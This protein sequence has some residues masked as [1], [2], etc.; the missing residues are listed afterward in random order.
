MANLPD[1]PRGDPPPPEARRVSNEQFELVIRRAAELQAE[2]DEGVAEGLSEEEV[3]R[4][5]RELGLTG[6]NLQRALA[7]V[8]RKTTAPTGALDRYM[9]AAEA[10]A[11][12]TIPMEP[13]RAR[14]LLEGHLVQREFYEVQRRF[15][16][17]L[18]LVE[19]SGVGAAIG[20]AASQLFQ[21]LPRLR[22]PNLEVAVR[23]LEEGYCYVTL[24][25]TFAAQ[26]VNYAAGGVIGG[27]LMGTGAGAVL[28][29]A[30]A[31]PAA[32]VGLPILGIAA[33]GARW[34]YRHELERAQE[35]LEGLLDRLEH[36]EITPPPARPGGRR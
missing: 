11:G 3:L 20:R 24:T 21:R 1:R 4:I 17:R 8:R 22:V 6:A 2:A 7:E 25:T 10:T 18:L 5:G 34:S 28:A 19:A 26:R 14:A 23:P 31:P 36:G 16:D 29:I 15:P 35:Q 32:I 9:G 13:D 33:L 30:I 12:R 27:G